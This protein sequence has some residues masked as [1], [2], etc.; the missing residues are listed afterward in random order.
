MAC[1][2][3][4]CQGDVVNWLTYQF[5]WS[6]MSGSKPQ[7]MT[8]WSCPAARA[9]C[10]QV[11]HLWHGNKNRSHKIS[12]R[13]KLDDVYKGLNSACVSC[14]IFTKLLMNVVGGGNQEDNTAGLTL[15]LNSGNQRPLTSPRP[16]NVHSSTF[17]TGEPFSRIQP[18]D[19]KVLLRPSVLY[20]WLNS[21]MAFI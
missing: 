14:W 21:D 11:S 20:T 19:N 8:L 17:H 13:N 2:C 3:I 16:W 18:W 4:I 1:E 9:L 10:P 12:L 15:E 7:L 5:L 6:G